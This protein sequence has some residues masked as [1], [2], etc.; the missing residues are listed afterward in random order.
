MGA[1]ELPQLDCRVISVDATLSDAEAAGCVLLELAAPD[2]E[3]EVLWCR[4]GRLVPRLRAGFP[5][6][7]PMGG[8]R[9]LEVA[10]P[11]LHQLPQLGL[12]GSRAV[13]GL[14]RSR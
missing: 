1:N 3:A 2:R 7:R 11:G 9:R 12:G 4:S 8:P 14:A 6:G 10:R 5:P 13:P